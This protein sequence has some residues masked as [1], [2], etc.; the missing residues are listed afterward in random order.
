MPPLTLSCQ[1]L[2]G[3]V[4]VITVAGEV[5][6]TTSDQL[7]TFIQQARRQPSDHL[8]V[9]LTEMPFMDSSGLSVLIRAYVLAH[10]HGGSLRLAAPPPVP[11]R[12]L[13]ITGLDARLPVHA[14]TADALAAASKVE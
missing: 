12:L 6:H 8:V 13:R 1:H 4:T 3:A 5:D 11:A 10:Q 2:P 7:D 14:T 9:E